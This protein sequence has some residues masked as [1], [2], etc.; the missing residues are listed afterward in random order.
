MCCHFHS[1]KIIFIA[2]NVYFLRLCAVLDVAVVLGVPIAVFALLSYDFWIE[3]TLAVFNMV[4]YSYFCL[5]VLSYANK[6]SQESPN[7]EQDEVVLQA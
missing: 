7:L 6:I 4:F 1:I 2:R 5:V 3:I